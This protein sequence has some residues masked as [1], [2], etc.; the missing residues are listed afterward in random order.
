[1]NKIELN[2]KVG[3]GGD[4]TVLAVAMLGGYHAVFLGRRLRMSDVPGMIG[5][6]FIVSRFNIGATSWDN[7]F[8]TSDLVQALSRFISH[9]DDTC[10]VFQP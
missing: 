9:I 1:V 5:N 2:A 6:E 3:P 4:V 7:G 10:V 8:Y